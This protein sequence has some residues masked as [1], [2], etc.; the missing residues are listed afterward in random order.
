MSGGLHGQ[1][2]IQLAENTFPLEPQTS[3]SMER[4]GS[5]GSTST[6]L[7][8]IMS[9]CPCLIC[10]WAGVKAVAGVKAPFA[11]TAGASVSIA[12]RATCSLSIRG[13]SS[14][15]VLETVNSLACG[16]ES[17]WAECWAIGAVPT[18]RFS[19]A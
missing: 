5:F 10:Q 11:C 12:R 3:S 15:C 2:G 17:I 9:N 8:K 14:E 19:S 1:S 18:L 13:C 6:S 7:A 16:D 4:A